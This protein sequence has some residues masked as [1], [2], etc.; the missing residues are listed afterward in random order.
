MKLPTVSD[1]VRVHVDGLA[2]RVPAGCS[3]AAALAWASDSHP[4]LAGRGAGRISVSGQLRAPLCG[5]GVCHECR[6]TI[7]GRL[8]LACQTVCREDMRIESGQSREPAFALP[9]HEAASTA[10]C[11]ILIVGAGPAGMA[12]ALA[13][14]PSGA[15]IVVI[16][17]NA[18]P[19]GQIWRDGP[20]ASPPAQALAMRAR[21]ER[22]S[23]VQLL[24]STRVIGLGADAAG[25]D[26]IATLLLEN[27]ERGWNQ[28]ADRLILCNGARELLL[29]F[30]GWTL[31]GVTGAGGLQA[32]IKGGMP[33]RGQRIVIAG[34]G[35]LLLAAADAARKAGASVLRIAEAAGWRQLTRFASGL[36][37]WPRKAMQ[38]LALFDRQF[39]A[40]CSVM[41]A[42]G[43]DRVRGVRLLHGDGR[44]EA[45]DC[46]RLACGFG[47]VP[48]NEL[49]QLLGCALAP[50]G[51][52]AVDAGQETSVA[53][54]HAAGECTGIGGS[55]RALVQGAIAG[56]A[57][58]GDTC[59]ASA[60]RSEL[61]HWQS[62]ADAVERHFTPRGGAGPASELETLICRC[63]DVRHA[64]V[65]ARSGWIDAKLH[66]RC[67][68]G[69]CQGRICGAAARHLFGWT[70]TPPRH[71]LTPARI[72]TL[73]S[74]FIEP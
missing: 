32:L 7:D 8:R 67:G 12:A 11:D 38:A 71:L 70:P 42:L 9:C 62:F 4:A 1:F 68:M 31:P 55:E 13:A 36:P 44:Q 23:N 18:A 53:G 41:E 26:R 72:E 43:D 33:V 65:A 61:D 19:G 29:P 40:G 20:Q 35:P 27:A 15:S 48:N 17:D 63:E 47:L 69:A 16:D 10:H 58:I 50:H 30:P 22:H 5:M 51:G 57:A 21:L 25:P 6:S 37:R 39:R 14:A 2:V 49:G 34:T 66:T 28:S 73:A 59:S 74:S 45:L 3:A 46:D 24:S 52:L 64:D 60:R 54:I 56:R